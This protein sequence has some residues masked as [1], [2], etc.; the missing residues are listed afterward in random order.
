MAKLIPL[1]PRSASANRWNTAPHHRFGGLY[2]DNSVFVHPHFASPCQVSYFWYLSIGN[3]KSYRYIAPTSSA[4]ILNKL[5]RIESS[6]LFHG[7]AI[8]I[9]QPVLTYHFSVL[10]LLLHPNLPLRVNPL[11]DG[12]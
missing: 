12:Y 3:F 6:L 1:L 2:S 7:L 11:T 5:P 9:S 10:Y 4:V 8:Q